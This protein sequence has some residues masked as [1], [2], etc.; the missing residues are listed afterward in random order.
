MFEDLHRPLGS[1]SFRGAVK[2]IIL[3]TGIL[4]V[5][6]QFFSS[7]LISWF[8]LTPSE[9]IGHYRIWQLFTYPFLHGGIFHWLF[10]MFIVWM[11]GRELEVRWGTKTFL[12]YF[13]LTA[14]GAGLFVL[15]LSPHSTTPTIGSS[16]A[17][18]G[19][20]TAFAVLFPDAVIYLYF[21]I[22]MKAWHAMILFGVIE[23]FAGLS[24]SGEGIARFA[25]LGGMVTGYFY[26]T[27]A[28]SFYRFRNWIHLKQRSIIPHRDKKTFQFHEVT[29]DLVQEVD[30]ILEKVSKEGSQ[31]LNAKEREI[32]DRYSKLRK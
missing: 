8:G 3:I 28:T 6:Q 19:L 29:D 16:G 10:N 24:S 7:F 25:H 11:V 32:M 12:F 5:L 15:A 23:L 30:R 26:L 4:L 9:V 2:W 31:S 22:P 13:F 17:V 18:F 21:V 27:G 20:L 1:T 14:V